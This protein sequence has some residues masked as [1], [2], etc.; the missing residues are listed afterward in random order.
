LPRR[1]DPESA[2]EAIAEFLTDLRDSLRCVTNVQPS[3]FQKSENIFVIFFADPASVATRA[4]GQLFLSGTQNFTVV[5]TV[6]GHFRAHTRGYSYI[7][8]EDSTA[9]TKGDVSYHCHPFDFD[10]R[11]PHLHLAYE[12]HVTSRE[13]EKKIARAHYPTSRV[14]LE[15]FILLLINYYDVKPI[16][17]KSVWSRVLERNKKKFVANATW[18]VTMP[19]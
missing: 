9:T 5:K 12:P 1:P 11:T 6:D 14:C 18:F 13:I 7:L 3:A 19:Q 15:D 8:A 17:L 16:G 2:Q 4:G 10:L